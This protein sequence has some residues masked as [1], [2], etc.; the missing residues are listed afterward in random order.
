MAAADNTDNDISGRD[1]YCR[2]YNNFNLYS[3]SVYNCIVIMVGKKLILVSAMI[4]VIY[5]QMV[6]YCS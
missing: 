5:W 6:Q 4:I 3:E 1:D 2:S